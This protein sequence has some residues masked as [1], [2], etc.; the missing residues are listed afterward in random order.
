MA[1]EVDM[2][3]FFVVAVDYVDHLQSTYA[4]AERD[5]LTEMLEITERLLQLYPCYVMIIVKFSLL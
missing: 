3:P 4:T 5:T 1:E 2:E